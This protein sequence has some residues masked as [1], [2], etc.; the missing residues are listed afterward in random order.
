MKTLLKTAARVLL[1]WQ[2]ILNLLVILLIT[3]WVPLLSQTVEMRDADGNL[4]QQATNTFRAYQSWWTV[5]RLAPG[6]RGHLSAVGMHF[7]LCF[8]ITF[9]V[10]VWFT[11][12]R[13][14]RTDPLLRPPEELTSGSAAGDDIQEAQDPSESK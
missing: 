2:F 6:W 4:M 13:V 8:A 11:A 12:I 3:C 10:W 1:S 5:V 14:L 9:G 7:G